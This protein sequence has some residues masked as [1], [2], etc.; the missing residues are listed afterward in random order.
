M[1]ELFWELWSV[2]CESNRVEL[3]MIL[4]ARGTHIHY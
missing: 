2:L 3:R 1:L 4:Q